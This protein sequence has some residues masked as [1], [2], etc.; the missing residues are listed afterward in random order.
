MNAQ[1]HG[2][3]VCERADAAR[4]PTAHPIAIVHC[5]A[6]GPFPIQAELLAYG[7]HGQQRK[8]WERL[9]EGLRAYL[10]ATKAEREQ[11]LQKTAQ[12]TWIELYTISV[13]NWQHFARKGQKVRGPRP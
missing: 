12:D 5:P 13:K 8:D 7:W 6:C 10:Q 1:T 2:C 3:P 11:A 4:T 9:R